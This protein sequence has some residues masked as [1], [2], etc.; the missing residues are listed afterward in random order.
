MRQEFSCTRFFLVL[1]F[2]SREEQSTIGRMLLP[3]TL[4]QG[5]AEAHVRNAQR[6]QRRPSKKARL[7]RVCGIVMSE[8]AWQPGEER[9]QLTCVVMTSQERT[10]RQSGLGNSAVMGREDNGGQAWPSGIQKK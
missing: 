1:K 4:P 3:T 10:P 2:I 6:L 5:G 9:G 8:E 7:S